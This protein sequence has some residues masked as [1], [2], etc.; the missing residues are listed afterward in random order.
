MEW[1]R[2]ERTMF[3]LVVRDEEKVVK[4]NK[5]GVVQGL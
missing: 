1:N 4:G 5:Q 3:Q 2:N